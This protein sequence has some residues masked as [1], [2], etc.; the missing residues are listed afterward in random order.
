MATDKT[1]LDGLFAG[2][3]KAFNRF[4]EDYKDRFEAFFNRHFPNI[5]IAVSEIYQEAMMELWKQIS[6]GR[7]TK[8]KL[9]VDI[10]T[11]LISIGKIKL[12]EETRKKNKYSRLRKGERVFKKREFK[13][14]NEQEGENTKDFPLQSRKM[15]REA[16]TNINQK[17]Y[18]EQSKKKIEDREQEVDEETWGIK[19]SRQRYVEYQVKHME[20]PCRS[21]IRD[22]W[23]NDMSDKELI[24]ANPILYPSTNAI[25]TR[26]FRCHQKLRNLIKDNVLIKDWYENNL[27]N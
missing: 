13:S 4:D 25:K 12:Y 15:Q 21:V 24:E 19:V 18:E 27:K 3:R 23:W 10:T 9:T 7:L 11:Y 14:E 5:Q 26:R 17:D 8:E 20:E 6:D 22:T 2:D 16:D 1:I